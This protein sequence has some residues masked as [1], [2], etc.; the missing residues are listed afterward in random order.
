MV[1][2]SPMPGREDGEAKLAGVQR[3][4]P[5][6]MSLEMYKRLFGSPNK[7]ALR[8][9]Q[10]AAFDQSNLVTPVLPQLAVPVG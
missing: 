1:R 2:R 6:S 8:M 9:N 10:R 3:S 5:G 7:N 4:A